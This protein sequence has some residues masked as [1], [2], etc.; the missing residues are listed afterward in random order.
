MDSG[1]EIIIF[2][3]YAAGLLVIFILAKIFS[4]SGRVLRRILVNSFCGG[5]SIILINIVGSSFGLHLPLNVISSFG[6]GTL[7]LPGLVLL[8][9][10]CYR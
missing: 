4:F 5:I 10:F 9:L 7:G 2:L 3:S 1:M 8:G 6:V